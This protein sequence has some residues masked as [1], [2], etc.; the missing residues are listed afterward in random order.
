MKAQCTCYLELIEDMVSYTI[1]IRMIG[2]KTSL[3]KHYTSDKGKSIQ[4]EG[5]SERKKVGLDW[6]W[7]S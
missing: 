2:M 7:S 6:S 5:T 1:I 3:A 4:T